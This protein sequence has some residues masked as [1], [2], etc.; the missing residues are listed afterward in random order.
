MFVVILPILI[1]LFILIVTNIRVV[2]QA[3]AFIIERL[4]RYV[5]TWRA[6]LP[7]KIPF[8]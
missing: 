8:I 5:Q 1:I 4:G 6:G 7:F 2:P 3:N